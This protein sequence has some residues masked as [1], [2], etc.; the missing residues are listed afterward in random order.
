MILQLRPLVVLGVVVALAACGS[1]GSTGSG[2]DRYQATVGGTTISWRSFDMPAIPASD[3][4]TYL[5]SRTGASAIVLSN[6]MSVSGGD[7]FSV[8]RQMGPG[9]GAS[10]VNLHNEC[11]DRQRQQQPQSSIADF[12]RQAE[13]A[14]RADG[15]C[16]WLGYDPSFDQQIRASGALAR[17]DDNRLFFT[18]MR[19]PD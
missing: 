7:C 2:G 19:C 10:A 11:I 1:S 6:G 15:R 13:Q 14:V 3:A 4:N 18:R 16:E 5:V 17:A 9:A 12:V 8:I